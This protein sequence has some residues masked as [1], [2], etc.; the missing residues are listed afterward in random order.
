MIVT[1]VLSAIICFI[2]SFF[3]GSSLMAQVMIMANALLALVYAVKPH[4]KV[5][6]FHTRFSEV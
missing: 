5:A 6:C 1:D 4:T 2:L 3:V